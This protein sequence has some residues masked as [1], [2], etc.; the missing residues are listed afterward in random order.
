MIPVHA[1]SHDVIEVIGSD[2]T[3]V[4]QVGFHEHVVQLLVSQVFS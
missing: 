2:E 4:I 1:V 3:I